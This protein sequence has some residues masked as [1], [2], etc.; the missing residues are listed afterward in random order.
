[1]ENRRNSD[2]GRRD[3]DVGRRKSDTGRRNSDV[4]GEVG[5]DEEEEPKPF[6]ILQ[7]I[8]SVLPFTAEHKIALAAFE[9]LDNLQRIKKEKAKANDL[10][11]QAKIGQHEEVQHE[12]AF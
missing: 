12:I 8:L 11:I 10:M 2:N 5:D 6:T 1:M 7:S 9:M 3:S 4:G